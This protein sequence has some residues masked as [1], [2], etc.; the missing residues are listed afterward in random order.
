MQMPAWWSGLWHKEHNCT[1]DY[2]GGLERRGLSAC[3]NC[4]KKDDRWLNVLAGGVPEKKD[5]HG[6]GGGGGG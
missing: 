2:R 6:G 1:G 4:S 3:G 5:K